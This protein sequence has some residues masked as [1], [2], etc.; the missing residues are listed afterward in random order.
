MDSSD[1]ILI[2]NTTVGSDGIISSNLIAS[3][4]VETEIIGGAAGPIGPPGPIGP[5]GLGIPIGGTIN[6]V[7]AKNSATNYDT[8]WADPSTVPDATT[9]AKGIVQL[10]GDLA[11]TAALPT[12]PGLAGKVA[13]SR[14][15]NGHALTADV[16]VTQADVG[17]GNVDNT[18]DATKNSAAV[19]LTNK[20]LTTPTIASF[21]NAQHNHTNAAGGGLLT[22][23]A[24]NLSKTTDANGWTVFAFGNF[25]LYT[26]S[27]STSI[28]VTNGQRTIA[29]QIP[30]PS[31]E[32]TTSVRLCGLT[33]EGNFAGHATPG[34]E[35]VSGS[36]WQISIG[37]EWAGGALTFAGKVSVIAMTA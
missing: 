24:L 21:T 22:Q 19:T 13:T 25:K 20:T 32:T 7:I 35:A 3:S 27:L 4:T 12:V 16:I 9:I 29:G 11:G 23:A 1:D 8:K 28:N 15:I 33:W 36:G 17:L 5:G 6:Q 31:G 37:N 14:T 26:Y 10:A 30:L 34:A 18:S 2:I